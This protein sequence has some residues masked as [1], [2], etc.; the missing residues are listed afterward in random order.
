MS[1]RAA[2]ALALSAALGALHPRPLPRLVALLVVVAGLAAGRP[3]VLGLGVGLL[4]SSLAAASWAGL[5]PPATGAWSGPATLVGDPEALGTVVR[6]DLRIEGKRVEAWARSGAAAALRPLLAGET[7]WVSGRLAGLEP[8]DARRLARRHVGGRLTVEEARATGDGAL[9]SRVANR[10]RR[11]LVEGAAALPE[12]QRA[13]FTGFVLGDGRGQAPEVVQDFRAAGLTHLLVVSG[14]NVAFVLALAGPALGRLGRGGRLAATLAVLALFGTLTRWEPSVLRAVGMA[15]VAVTAAAGGRPAS[16]RRVLALTVTALLVVDPLLVGALGFLLSVGASAGLVLWSRPLARALPGP[17]PVAEGLAT[18]LAAQAGVAPVLV[19]AFG[20]VPVA[21][22]AANLLAVPAAGPL[23]TWGLTAGSVAGV[24]GG[25]SAGALHLPTRALLGWEA[26][27]ARVGAALPLGM[28]RG[29]Q[30]AALG[31]AVLAVAV[32]GRQGRT[33]LRRLAGVGA[34]ACLL[35]PA[36][37]TAGPRHLVGARVA[38]GATLW[39]RGSTAV[40]VLEGPRGQ[41]DWL[42]AGL[43]EHGVRR[44]DLVVATRGTKAEAG[45]VTV[46]SRRLPPGAVLA[47]PGHRLGPRATTVARP[48]TLA[49]G[50]VVVAVS[51]AGGRLAATVRGPPRP[52]GSPDRPG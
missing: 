47:P 22:L 30:V 33:G 46:L 35:L 16:A 32:A 26:L 36:L 9:A 12:G 21:S 24:V 18:T 11:N 8:A 5:H 51:V 49:L 1:D 20:G 14:Q 44:L 6:A 27:V 42:L 29:P 31:V 39:Q 15:A 34:G 3:L 48:L 45:V 28:L 41:P 40:L 37:T 4:T 38:D 43:Q 52:V 10:V 7:T 13:L 50:Q 19:P 17:R 23:M 25:A 2:A